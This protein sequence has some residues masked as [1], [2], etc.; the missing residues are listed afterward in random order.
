MFINKEEFANSL[1]HGIGAVILLITAPV[2]FAQ[3]P[4]KVIMKWPVVVFLFCLFITFLI[5]SVYHAV[6]DEH[7]KKVFRVFDHI[8]I[9]MLIGGTF[10]PIVIYNMGGWNGWPFLA[11]FWGAM[12]CGVVFK[13]FFTGK[14]VY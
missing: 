9:F 1:T 7:Y 10:T 13:V 11:V 8:S 12:V 6:T 3:F 4:G 5:S 2:L 14:H